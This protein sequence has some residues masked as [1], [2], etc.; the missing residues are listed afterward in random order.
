VRA[1]RHHF[2]HDHHKCGP[3]CTFGDW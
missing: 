3:V 2:A 1:I